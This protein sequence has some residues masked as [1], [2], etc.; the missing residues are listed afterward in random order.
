MKKMNIPLIA[1]LLGLSLIV[2]PLLYIYV[3]PALDDLQLST[4]KTLGI[5]AGCSALYC[6]VV[7]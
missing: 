4:L 3:G 6:F 2:C 5:I 1:T 7:G